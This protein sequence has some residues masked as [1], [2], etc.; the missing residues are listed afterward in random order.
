MLSFLKMIWGKIPEMLRLIFVL[1][2]VVAAIFLLACSAFVWKNIPHDTILEEVIEGVIKE[3]S[4][5]D[6]DLTPSSPE[7]LIPIPSFL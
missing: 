6:L 1:S 7:N 5:L 3:K 2:L 4:G